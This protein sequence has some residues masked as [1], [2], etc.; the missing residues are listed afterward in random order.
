MARPSMALGADL[1]AGFPTETE[2][3]FANTLA[4]V[5]EC[6]LDLLHVFPF[7]PRHGTPAAKMPQ[8]HGSVVKERA[9]RLR[10]VATI[11]S[12]KFHEGLV[13][14]AGHAIVEKDGEARLENFARV[15]FEGD[16]RRGEIMKLA[17]T[18]AAHDHVKGIL[19]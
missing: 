1:I 7:S 5:D 16:A 8:L 3:M 14:G 17:I 2:D 18:G 9:A 15:V 4:L 11:R 12:Q 10:E 6:A 19:L 13:G